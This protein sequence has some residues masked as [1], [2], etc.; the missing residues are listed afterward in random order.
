MVVVVSGGTNGVWRIYDCLCVCEQIPAKH[1]SSDLTQTEENEV[2]A[3]LSLRD[4]VTKLLYV[5]PE[6]VQFEEGLVCRVLH[7]LSSML[8][9]AQCQPQI[10]VHSPIFAQSPEVSQVS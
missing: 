5:T 10:G 8:A 2:Y 7:K 3:S 6:K 9:A 1:L 4:P